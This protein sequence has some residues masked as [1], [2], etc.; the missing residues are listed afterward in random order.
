MK[1][2]AT[3]VPRAKKRKASSAKRKNN[4]GII[5]GL[6]VLNS[7]VL[8]Y[9]S[10]KFD[11]KSNDFANAET[12]VRSCYLN[13]KNPVAGNFTQNFYR[14][15]VHCIS[16][17]IAVFRPRF[18]K[19]AERFADLSIKIFF[20]DFISDSDKL[21]RSRFFNGFRELFKLRRFSAFSR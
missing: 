3:I 19:N 4:R 8:L 5:T 20:P 17:R 18:K 12:V 2:S 15:I 9:L 7:P 6:L 14:R 10:K 21:S 1:A 13:I 11:I 16:F